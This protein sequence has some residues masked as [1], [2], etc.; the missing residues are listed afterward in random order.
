MRKRKMKNYLKS[1][2]LLFG[3]SIL[4]WNCNKVYLEDVPIKNEIPINKL[5]QTVSKEESIAY[6][7]KKEDKNLSA[8]I[9]PIGLEPDLDNITQEEILNT[10]AE[11]TVI[12]AETN[13]PEV[14]TRILQVKS[15]SGE[16]ISLLFNE[17]PDN[18]STYDNFSGIIN[19]TTLD[20][21]IIDAYRVVNGDAISKFEKKP[22]YSNECDENLNPF[23]DF[24][25][26]QLNEII[27]SSTN[28]TATVNSQLPLNYGPIYNS[29]VWRYANNGYYSYGLSYLN[30]LR[31]LPCDDPNQSRNFYGVCVENKKPCAGNPVNNP[32]I[33][34]S[35]LSGKKGGTF[36]CTRTDPASSCGG[37]K[38]KKSH[39]GIDLKAEPN[40]STYSMNDG[41]VIDI[42]D[43]FSPGQYKYRS[44]GNYVIIQSEI[45][46]QTIFIKYNHL[47]AVSVIKGQTVSAGNII[48]LSGTT[49][50]IT[51]NVIP[52]IHLQVFTSSWESINPEDF[53]TTKFDTNQNS[54]PNSNCN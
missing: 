41:K 9:D 16:L 34:S 6:F 25:F 29:Y 8:R 13:F 2:I 19:L 46:G 15:S 47:N 54:I 48:G 17:I 12:P 3:I 51:S 50:N 53:L 11:L 18:M 22:T 39:D 31:S 27:L 32:E 44:Y 42:R 1:G 24:C 30:Y 21:K 28:Y 23:S 10:D 43:S 35:G 45:N 37:V 36:G 26:Q 49:G 40:S 20:G 38:G 4:L 7:R 5:F 14:K 33:V 52:H